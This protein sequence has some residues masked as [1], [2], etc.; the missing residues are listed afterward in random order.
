M[1]TSTLWSLDDLHHALAA[2]GAPVRVEVR[3]AVHALGLGRARG[4]GQ[5]QLPV[6]DVFGY[7]FVRRD[8]AKGEKGDKCMDRCAMHSQVAH[9]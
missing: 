2:G 5:R 7:A 3:E 1:F 8:R 6:L 4:H 9:A